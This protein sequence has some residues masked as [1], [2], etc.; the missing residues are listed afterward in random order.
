MKAKQKFLAL[1]NLLSVL[2][3]IGVNYIS[4]A[5][6][7]NDTTIGEV[8]NT[9]DNLFTPASYAFSIWG[10]IFLGLIVFSVFQIKRAFFSKES[11]EFIGQIGYW[12][13]LANLLNSAWVIAFVYD[14]T[15]LSVL[16][17]LGILFSLIKII[18]NTNMERWDAP[19][20]TIAFVW[21]PICLYG[22]WIAVATIAN[23][24][25]FLTKLGWTGAPLSE[26]SWTLILITVATILNLVI[27]R[28][29]FMREFA[30]VG[31]WALVAIA[32]RHWN[33]YQNIAIG[34]LIGGLL[35]V[36]YILWQGF[37]NRKSNPFYNSP[38]QL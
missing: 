32:V 36:G 29:R 19:K 15:G 25:A 21:W 14:H 22:G 34:A 27:I 17:M 7:L 28:T 1:L 35:L 20:A 10:L 13:C 38:R 3:V 9:Y 37:N 33:T 16:I 18:L 5:V 4:Q 12:F 30:A 26:I 6:R 31:V 8:S 24:A 2:L 23:V 11:T